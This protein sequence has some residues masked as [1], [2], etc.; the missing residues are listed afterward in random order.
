MLPYRYF[1]AEDKLFIN[2]QSIGFAL[3]VG[4]DR[5]VVH[6]ESIQRIFEFFF[7][8]ARFLSSFD[9]FWPVVGA[10]CWAVLEGGPNTG[11]KTDPKTDQKLAET[12]PGNK[13]PQANF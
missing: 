12:V 2:T 7:D 5:R 10:M 13:K 9:Q 1:D 8:L 6:M 3:E 4:A 11:Q